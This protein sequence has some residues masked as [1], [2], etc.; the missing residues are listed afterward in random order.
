[1]TNNPR[2]IFCYYTGEEPFHAFSSLDALSELHNPGN[3]EK[4]VDAKSY[5]ALL[6]QAERM[7][8]AFS[9]ISLSH[10]FDCATSVN[11]R[12]ECSCGYL[13]AKE[14]LKQWQEFN[15]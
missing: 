7:A 12:H 13:E 3:A 11:G 6:E 5:Q 15:K 14:A 10:D 9:K 2:E 1:M 8:E 4:Y